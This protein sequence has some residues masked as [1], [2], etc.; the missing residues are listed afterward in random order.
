MAKKIAPLLPSTD[1]L[2]H[3][4]G[5]RLRLARQRRRLSAKQVAERAGM[6]PMTLRS[7]E[8][9]GSGVTM[10]A[11]LAVMQV[12]GVEK[13]LDLLAKAD[14]LGRELQDARLPAASK[15]A[16]TAPASPVSSTRLRR[17]APVG[18]AVAE[19]HRLIENTPQEKL[20]RAVESMPSEQ[21]RKA[22]AALPFEQLRA[23]LDKLET[24]GRDIKKLFKSTEADQDWIT[25]SG[26]ASSDA[27]A[28][29]IDP[30]APFS[31]KGR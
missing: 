15:M 27:L 29:M 7:L 10:G 18:D 6:S 21:L 31:K 3:Q 24:P 12:L 4:F 5:G 30:L 26:F 19:L 22:M 23:T 20:R 25:K 14:P 17:S 11:Y 9:G 16:R 1:D 28:R 13:D 8:R 2:L